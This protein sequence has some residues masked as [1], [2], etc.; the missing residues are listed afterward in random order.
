MHWS[1]IRKTYLLKVKYIKMLEFH[2]NTLRYI[3]QVCWRT[4]SETQQIDGMQSEHISFQSRIQSKTNRAQTSSESCYTDLSHLQQQQQLRTLI[5]WIAEPGCKSQVRWGG[6]IQSVHT[7]NCS[8]WPQ[9]KVHLFPKQLFNFVKMC[10]NK[11]VR[12]KYFLMAALP[13]HVHI[14]YTLHANMES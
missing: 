8:L 14:L 6:K 7:S 4:Q 2:T 11:Q 12:N 1:F 10:L 3:Q 5:W 9:E 13:L